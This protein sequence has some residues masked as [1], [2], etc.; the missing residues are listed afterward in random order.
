MNLGFEFRSLANGGVMDPAQFERELYSRLER[1]YPD[2]WRA[3]YPRIYTDPR[4]GQYYSSRR[5]ARQ[6]MLIA[7]KV[8]AG[9]VAES[10]TYEYH[11]ASHLAKFR[12][13]EP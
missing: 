11:L 7:L 5:P 12:S 9:Q 10:E 4:N 6:I 2:L 13:E 8:L 1:E 3:C